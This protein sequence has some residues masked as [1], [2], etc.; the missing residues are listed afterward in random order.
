VICGSRRRSLELCR[1]RH[2]S[3]YAEVPVMPRLLSV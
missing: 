1:C 2:N 3:N